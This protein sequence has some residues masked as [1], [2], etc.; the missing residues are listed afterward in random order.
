MI[1]TNRT[2]RFVAAS[3]VFFGL[4]ASPGYA[5]TVSVNAQTVRV[6]GVTCVN[7]TV[8]LSAASID[9]DTSR[10]GSIVAIPVPP[11][12]SALSSRSGSVGDIITISGANFA[13]LT[14]LTI[15]NATANVSNNT[16]SQL[17]TTIPAGASVGV[18]GITVTTSTPPAYSIAFTVDPP[19]AAVAPTITSV[20]PTSGAV[21][22]TV[23][24][25][26]TGLG[27]ANSVT[28]NNTPATIT[29]NT[30]TQIITTVPV[31]AVVAIGGLTVTTA[32]APAY[33]VPFTVTQPSTVAAPT[34]TT[35]TP[36]SA[37][38]GTAVTI[39]G[40]GLGG[41]NVTIGGILATVAA[42]SATSI[43]T[44]V[45]SGASLGAGTVVVTT[46]GGSISSPFTVNA[47]SV[48]DVSFDGVP[49]PNPSLLPF[50]VP[51]FHGGLNGAGA[52][53]NAYSMN[54]ARCTTTPPLTRSWQHN[55]DIT[56]HKTRNALLFFAMNAGEALSYK[57][58]VGDVDVSG[59]FLYLDA[60]N[61]NIRP[62]V[63]SIT[64]A[65]C[66][67]NTDKLVIGPNRDACY[68]TGING[69]GV[70]WAN[71]TG[72]LPS[73]YCRLVKGQTYYFNIRFQDGR[74]ASLFG[75]PTTDSCTSGPCGG[76][77]QVL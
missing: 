44:T 58:T 4:A 55:I 73:S 64:S 20:I 18:G 37:S 74:P 50:Q 38:V 47:A 36:S 62:T 31:G 19:R 77:L 8:T 52:E 34:I 42:G 53:V 69:N 33:S 70:S 23:I 45:P 10:C 26:G 49:I 13:G 75:S 60:S 2:R 14:S 41:A 24:I 6:N 16:G 27:G 57:F 30:G 51:A 11:T 12:I 63:M 9:I 65:P 71:I 67:F 48:G 66:D 35:V 29:A 40:T 76:L 21:G 59:G 61:A 32:V 7:A 46:S 56:A 22:T 15:N 3:L 5:Q 68:Q 72:P 43:T 54:P 28:I 1:N 39:T 25:T 17:T